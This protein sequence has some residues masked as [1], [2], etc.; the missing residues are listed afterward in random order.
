MHT[1]HLCNPVL[2]SSLPPSPLQAFKAAE[3]AKKAHKLVLLC[4]DTPLMQTRSPCSVL[5][6]LQAFKAAEAAKKARELVRR[7][8]VLTKSTLP[9][10]L[11]D[12]SSSHKEE[13]EIFLVEGDS[14]GGWLAFESCWRKFGVAFGV[15][16]EVRDL[17]GGGGL[18]GWVQ[19]VVFVCVGKCISGLLVV[20]AAQAE[21]RS[22][23]LVE[24]DSAGVY[25]CCT[26]R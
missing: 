8:S 13:C 14:A 26:P 20:R 7:K 11:A 21:E 19:V 23:S 2:T 1:S 18:C 4:A 6:P 17:P 25:K 3:A 24:D 16:G 22:L 10:K 9:G 12:C 5:L 15:Q